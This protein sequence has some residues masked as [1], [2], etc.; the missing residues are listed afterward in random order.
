MRSLRSDR[1]SLRSKLTQSRGGGRRPIAVAVLVAALTVAGPVGALA[2]TAATTPT[3]AT[4]PDFFTILSVAVHKTTFVVDLGVPAPGTV[5]LK[6]SVKA[7][8]RHAV[9]SGPAANVDSGINEFKLV[10][11][12]TA[13]SVLAGVSK[14]TVVDVPLTVSYTET[15][16]GSAARKKTLH[17]AG[18]KK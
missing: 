11:C 16:G 17:V 4:S 12:P 2:D 14:H 6:A 3:T 18:L 1:S 7:N 5:K 13:K 15:G 8:G 10:A 9:C